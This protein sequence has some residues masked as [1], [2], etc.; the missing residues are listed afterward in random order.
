MICELEKLSD[1]RI[2]ASIY[3]TTFLAKKTYVH[4]FTVN[5]FC[6][7]QAVRGDRG[8]GEDLPVHAAGARGGAL[9]QA[10]SA[11]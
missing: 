7:W 11:R 10:H 1:Y 6:A 5:R 8:E 4:S 2:K 9:H 3:R